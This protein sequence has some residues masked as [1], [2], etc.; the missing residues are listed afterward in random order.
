MQGRL[1]SPMTINLSV[2]YWLTFFQGTLQFSWASASDSLFKQKQN[3]ARL[4]I[5]NNL[6]ITMEI[7]KNAKVTLCKK[8]PLLFTHDAGKGVSS[9]SIQL[10]GSIV[11][12][13]SWLLSCC[14]RVSLSLSS[15][16]DCIGSGDV[17]VDDS[18]NIGWDQKWNQCD[19]RSTLS[20]VSWER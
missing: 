17:L 2:P 1:A 15:K 12:G 9:F 7:Q 8:K 6:H 13:R 16:A 19:V 11:H 4:G 20:A 5:G 3:D 18:G 10:T 14:W